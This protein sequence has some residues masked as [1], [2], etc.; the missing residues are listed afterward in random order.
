MTYITPIMDRKL[1]DIQQQTAKGKF[2]LTDWAR[3]LNNLDTARGLVESI[4]TIMIAQSALSTPA[5]GEFW[6][7]A[8]FNALVR[9]IAAVQDAAKLARTDRFRLAA[10]YG[11]GPTGKTIQYKDVNAWERVL[12]IIVRKYTTLH[13]GRMPVTGI[14]IVGADMIRQYWFR[15]GV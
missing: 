11:N 2:S 15:K 1:T 7:A 14:E 9:N 10:D 8:H 13:K 3:I 12:D 4:H 5:Q 6:R